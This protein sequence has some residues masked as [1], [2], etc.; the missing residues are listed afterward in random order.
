MIRSTVRPALVLCICLAACAGK[1]DPA[2]AD[3]AAGTKAAGTTAAGTTAAGMPATT[4]QTPATPEQRKATDAQ[5]ASIASYRLTMDAFEEY[6]AA[7]RNILT[8]AS[9]MSPAEREAARARST[10]SSTAGTL[11]D[12]VRNIEREPMMSAAVREAGL[13]PRDFTLVGMA[14][15]QSGMVAGVLKQRPNENQDSLIRVMKA[16]AENVKFVMANE[17]ELTR[18]QK[19]LEADIN[20]LRAAAPKPKP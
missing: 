14:I 19:A 6:M 16:N 4:S 1:T 3:S 10:G 15:M 11:D 9:S 8:K 20:K 2:P 5:L 13:T 17:P 18:K 7:Q 12:M